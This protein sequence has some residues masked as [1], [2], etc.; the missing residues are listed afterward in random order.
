MSGAIYSTDVPDYG[1]GNEDFEYDE[2]RQRELDRA[3][4]EQRAADL[5]QQQTTT[6]ESS[7]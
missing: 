6:Q 4:A 1:P 2:A 3:E 7:K 5:L